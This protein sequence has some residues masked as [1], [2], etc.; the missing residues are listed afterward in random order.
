MA[1]EAADGGPAHN[2]DGRKGEDDREVEERTAGGG[3]GVAGAG[4]GHAPQYA[5]QPPRPSFGALDAVL[6][7]VQAARTPA[8]ERGAP[9]SGVAP[10][11]AGLTLGNEERPA[12][13]RDETHA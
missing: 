8:A 12:P 5:W 1:D 9:R 11:G 10:R 2:G 6:Y 4:G 13:P 7:R 3:P